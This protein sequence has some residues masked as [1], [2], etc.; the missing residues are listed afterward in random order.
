M[1]H[2]WPS[3]RTISSAVRDR[4]RRHHHLVHR[5]LAELGVFTARL[6]HE[7][8]A[9]F[10]RDEQLAV[11][12]D[13]RRRKRA[14]AADPRA[15]QPRAALDVIRG[16]DAVVVQRVELIAID[17]RRRD[18]GA[19]AIVAPG[20]GVA[21]GLPGRQRDVAARAGPHRV[22]RAHRRIPRGDDGEVAM[23]H[24]RA[25]RDLRIRRQR[26]QQRAG[27]RIV[28]AHPGAVGD[29]LVALGSGDDRRRRPRRHFIRPRRA[30]Q[31]AAGREIERAQ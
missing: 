14:A 20:N 22:D 9:V 13:R 8:V 17:D 27:G 15:I 3:V 5:I 30:P 23:H 31:L 21:R 12:G 18:I 28:A 1:P 29:E 16:Q 26:P 24:R 10:A 4:R 11:A 2:T 25:D 7:H 6:H 19:V